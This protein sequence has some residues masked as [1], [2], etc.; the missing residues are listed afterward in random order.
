MGQAG[1]HHGQPPDPET[2]RASG[3]NCG[4]PSK[5]AQLLRELF[6]VRGRELLRRSVGCVLLG[7][8]HT[9]A[10]SEP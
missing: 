10:N 6:V 3:R 7:V 2:I 1:Q 5:D 9:A 8:K 4:A